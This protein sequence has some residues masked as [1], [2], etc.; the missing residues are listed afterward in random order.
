[1]SCYAAH[2]Q[3]GMCCEPQ[4]AIS[5][6]LAIC[7]GQDDSHVCELHIWVVLANSCDHFF[8]ELTDFK[9]IALLNTA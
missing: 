8:P 1:M 6:M 5:K 9:H 4:T 3:S 2:A 7:A